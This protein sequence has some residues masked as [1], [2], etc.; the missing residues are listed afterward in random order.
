MNY[1]VFE[2][3]VEAIDYIA[4]DE[5]NFKSRV[6][7]CLIKAYSIYTR[8]NLNEGYI[9]VNEDSRIINI[10]LCDILFVETSSTP[11]KI[12]VHELNRQIEFYGNLKDMEVKLTQNFYRYVLPFI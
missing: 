5:D 6:T 9:K 8:K 10:K 2:Y 11:H 12:K 4:K 7:S 3:K 1:L